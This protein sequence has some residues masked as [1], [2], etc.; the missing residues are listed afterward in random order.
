M[1]KQLS[2]AI[3]MA[4]SF[5]ELLALFE[6]DGEIIGSRGKVYLFQD[7]KKRLGYFRAGGMNVNLITRTYG[8]RDM[9]K[10]MKEIDG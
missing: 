10:M 2:E 7:I 9:A 5:D 8:L 3:S 1:S 6:D 4:N